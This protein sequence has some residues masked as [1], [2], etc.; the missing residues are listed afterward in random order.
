MLHEVKTYKGHL[1]HVKSLWRLD[2]NKAHYWFACD[3]A[4]AIC[5]HRELKALQ[6]SCKLWRK[7]VQWPS[8]LQ[9]KCQLSLSIV[10]EASMLGVATNYEDKCVRKLAGFSASL[11]SQVLKR[12]NWLKGTALSLIL[13]VHFNIQLKSKK[14][15]LV[16]GHLGLW[17]NAMIYLSEHQTIFPIPNSQSNLYWISYIM[18]QSTPCITI[19]QIMT[20]A[21]YPQRL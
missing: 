10:M 21:Y 5:G 12:F 8:F 16:I 18:A 6:V 4:L 15:A 14:V 19:P 20:F 1:Y 13:Q 9:W 17:N 3:V 11:I 7:R 2:A